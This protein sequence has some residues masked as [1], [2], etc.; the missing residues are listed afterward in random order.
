LSAGGQVIFAWSALERDCP[1]IKNCAGRSAS[2]PDA[3]CLA[4]ATL[5]PTG[6]FSL[7]Q[8]ATH[9]TM[10]SHAKLY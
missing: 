5:C 2:G 1:E 8:Q 9:N 7:S 3:L 6:E 10:V 4:R